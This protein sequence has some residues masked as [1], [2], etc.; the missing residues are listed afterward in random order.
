MLAPVATTGIVKVS[1]HVFP[2]ESVK[3][4]VKESCVPTGQSPAM[5]NLKALDKKL[6]VYNNWAEVAEEEPL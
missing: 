3:V 4:T 5:V 6:V 2:Q 1:I